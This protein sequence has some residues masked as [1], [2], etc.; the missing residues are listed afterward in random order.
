MSVNTLT[1]PLGRPA[2]G[3]AESGRR[4]AVL[5]REWPVLWGSK[6]FLQSGETH[7]Q[8]KWRERPS[9]TDK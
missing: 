9:A 8:K 4:V 1:N 7:D 2:E 6:T 5:P 3:I